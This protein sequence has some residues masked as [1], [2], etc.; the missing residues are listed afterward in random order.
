MKNELEWISEEKAIQESKSW[1]DQKIFNE[2]NEEV[3]QRGSFT[4]C[5]LHASYDKRQY[6]GVGFSKARKEISLAQYD[7]ERGKQVAQGRAIH[8]LFNEIKKE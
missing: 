3:Y 6:E 1:L 5:I 2:V 8:D 4:V 7:S